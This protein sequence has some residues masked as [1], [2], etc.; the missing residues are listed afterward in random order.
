MVRFKINSIH[1]NGFKTAENG[2]ELILAETQTSTVYGKNGCGKTTLLYTINAVFD[3]NE[4]VLKE[5]RIDDIVLKCQCDGKDI[6][7]EAKAEKKQGEIVGYNF[8]GFDNFQE[9]SLFITTD[10]GLNNPVDRDIRIEDIQDILKR[11]SRNKNDFSI[12]L[13]SKMVDVYSF[14]EELNGLKEKADVE[15]LLKEKNLII[16]NI[17]MVTVE[18]LFCRNADNLPL[19]VLNSFSEALKLTLEIT[20]KELTHSETVELNELLK[21]YEEFLKVNEVL[22]GLDNKVMQFLYKWER[23]LELIIGKAKQSSDKKFDDNSAYM[24]IQGFLDN[25]K[26]ES[27]FLAYLNVQE[28]FSKYVENKKLLIEDGS[29]KVQVKNGVHALNELSNGERQFLTFLVVLAVLGKDKSVIMIDEPGISLDTDWQ[30][31][32]VS[33]IETLCPNSQIILT[34]HSPDVSLCDTNMICHLEID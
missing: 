15:D 7:L 28:M 17:T 29:V 1:I 2:A 13:D 18:E 31:D 16:E 22:S 4:Y 30:E 34:T 14:I 25:I 20:L 3:R 23:E 8:I 27:N 5:N 10:R 21:A 33:I 9:S 11:L 19:I 24:V 32:L 26:K 6:I 12:N